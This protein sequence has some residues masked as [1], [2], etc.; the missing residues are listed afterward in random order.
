M[1]L[2][3]ATGWGPGNGLTSKVRT[4]PNLS[5]DLCRG[6]A[7]HE[8][9]DYVGSDR[10]SRI[11]CCAEIPILQCDCCRCRQ[12][13]NVALNRDIG[14]VAIRVQRDVK[15]HCPL[16]FRLGRIRRKRSRIQLRRRKCRILRRYGL[17]L[18]WRWQWNV[19]CSEKAG[20]VDN[21]DRQRRCHGIAIQRR[22]VP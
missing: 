16:R 9:H 12:R 14:D 17:N 15:H 11:C 4:S 1:D 6:R 19:V 8:R 7:E 22:R 3:V 10:L 5:G 21:V 20:I 13:R 18:R 2:S